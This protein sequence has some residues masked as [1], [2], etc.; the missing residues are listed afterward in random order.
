MAG[1]RLESI[2]ENARR[3]A[4]RL[5]LSAQEI[6]QLRQRAAELS[7]LRDELGSLIS[8]LAGLAGD[9]LLGGQEAGREARGGG[10]EPGAGPADPAPVSP[11]P[12]AYVGP[13]AVSVGPLRDFAQL[14]S[15]EDAASRI[16]AAEDVQIRGFTDGRATFSMNFAQPVDLVRELEAYAPFGFSVRAASGDAVVLDVKDAA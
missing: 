4:D 13:V 10:T 3:R 8:E 1:D 5:R 9:L 12:D 16:G 14:T 15:F 7:K 2:Q 6:R 11:P